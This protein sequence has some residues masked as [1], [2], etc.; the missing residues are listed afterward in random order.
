[1]KVICLGGKKGRCWADVNPHVKAHTE[2]LAMLLQTASKHCT[3]GKI[4]C[5]IMKFINK[6]LAITTAFG[7]ICLQ[8]LCLLPFAISASRTRREICLV[9]CM[10]AGR[11]GHLKGLSVFHGAPHTSPGS[12]RMAKEKDLK[13]DL[14]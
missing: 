6:A 12:P 10:S 1:M 9:L 5:Q 4:G 3:E 8:C 14:A 11:K 2:M 7:L 13:R